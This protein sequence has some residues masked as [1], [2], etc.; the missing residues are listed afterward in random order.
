MLLVLAGHA[1]SIVVEERGEAGAGVEFAVN[2]LKGVEAHQIKRQRGNGNNWTLRDLQREKV[3]AAAAAQIKRGRTFRFVSLVPCRILDELA[4]RARTSDDP[5]TFVE[6]LTKELSGQ[7]E[8][9]VREWGSRDEAFLILRRLQVSWPDER[10]L[11]ETNAVI[12]ETVLTGARG[13]AAATVLADVAWDNLGK[14]LDAPA[15]EKAVAAYG[16]SPVQLTQSTRNEIGAT[17][18][19]WSQSVAGELLHPVIMRPEAEDIVERLSSGASRVLLV[20][21]P[22]G[23]GKSAVLYQAVNELARDWPVLAMRLDQ[24]EAFSSTHELGVDRLGLSASPAAA[25]AATARGEDCLLVIDQLDAVSLASGRMPT[26]FQHVAALIREATAFP[27]MRVLLA[28]R[29]FDIDNDHR[30]RELVGERG[31]AE[32]T[33]LAPLSQEQATAA[34]AAMGLDPSALS[35]RQQE[36]LRTPLHLVLLQA[37]A[38]EGAT[39]TFSSAKDLMDAFY[40]QKR[41]VCDVHAG[42]KVRFFAVVETLVGHMS[43]HQ[44]LFAPVAALDADDLQKDAEVMASEHVLVKDGNRVRFF[45]EAFFDYAFARSWLLRDEPLVEFLL[46]GQQELFRRAQVRQVLVH[47]RAEDPERFLSEV[48]SLLSHPEIR[49]HVK[50]VV[51]GLLRAIDSPTSSDWRLVKR[52]L[53]TEPPFVE[54]LWSLLRTPGWFDRL[55]AEGELTSWLSESTERFGR[56]IDVMVSVSRQRPIR[57]AELLSGLIDDSRYG[58]ALRHISFYVD[59]HESRAMTDLVIDG[60]RRGLF[61]EHAHG[62][63]MSAHGL[64]SDEP[65]WASELLRAWF[66]ERADPYELTEDGHVAALIGSD[67]GAIE[68]IGNT[69]TGA[70]L[71]FARFAIPYLLGAMDATTSGERLPYRDEHFG[72]RVFNPGHYDVDDAVLYGAR[73]ALRTMIAAG[74]HSEV[75]PLLELLAEDRHDAAQWLLYETLATDGATYVD[76]IVELLSQGEHRL[77]SGYL[78]DSFWTA[79]EL[80]IA[81]SP[82]LSDVQSASLEQIFLGLRP[83]WEERPPGRSTWTF[84]TALSEERLTEAG[85]R[86]LQELTRIFGARPPP[87]MGIRVGAIG[88]PIP[89]SRAT[90]MTDGQWLRAVAKHSGDEGSRSLWTGG[91]R[92]QAQVLREVTQADPQRFAALALQFSETTHPAYADAVLDGLAST[93]ASEQVFQVMRHIA[94]FRNPEND[95]ALVRAPSRFSP[96]IPDDIVELLLDRALHSADPDHEAWQEEAS[97]G[98]RYY[99]GDPYGNGINTARGA[100]AY[101]LGEL[102]LDDRDGR[103]TELVAP[104]FGALAADPSVAV[105]T[106]VARLF[107]AGLRHARPEVVAALPSLLDAPD[108]LLSAGPVQSLIIFLGFDDNALVEPIIQRMLTSPVES[109]RHRGGEMAAFA[110]LE[111][112]LPDFLSRAQY[113]DSATREG[114][115]RTCARR[116]PITSDVALAESALKAF[117]DDDDAVVRDSAAEVAAALRDRPLAKH[118]YLVEALIHSPAYTDALPQLLITLEHATEPVDRL[119]LLAARRFLDCFRGGLA[120]VATRAAG[121]SKQVGELVLRAYAQATDVR[122]RAQALD[123]IDELLIANAY[124]FSKLIDEAVR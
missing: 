72:Y 56:A 53:D 54:Q 49:F 55:D 80:V 3:L 1:T 51:I 37:I 11:V 75:H 113:G 12:A 47:L 70:A 15:I 121:D 73:D 31:P 116:L 28:C 33:P 104:A 48:G 115:A 25:L 39:L 68:I 66:L 41:R 92:Q 95:R 63:F 84:L 74:A 27:R 65:R 79:R 112:D 16:L 32:Q 69:A 5:M 34:V 77:L 124:G 22:A 81:A 86:R 111:L 50:S 58:D 9:L 105:R 2:G 118:E 67:H 26:S 13:R 76:W 60:V 99:G 4:T 14:T 45:H 114:A 119:V 87:P 52:N 85:H 94:R 96:D 101:T 17:F 20:S 102:L 30:L 7:L 10:H 29:Q 90:K 6:G 109:T 23:E 78:C 61:D 35:D 91:A 110:T 62:L 64:G 59:L 42:V 43:A 36:L 106:C 88:P 122:S 93:E 83:V 120:D 117:F 97:S 89:Q 19:S 46:S 24:I 21:G 108:E 82:H 44:R 100:A 57:L 38:D 103:L 40:E 98:Q 107:A 18:E 71:D 123:L 8:V